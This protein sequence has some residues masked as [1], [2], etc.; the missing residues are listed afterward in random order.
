M[1]ET[2]VRKG[3]IEL[4]DRRK[5]GPKNEFFECPLQTTSEILVVDK[6][7]TKVLATVGG[8]LLNRLART[9]FVRLGVR[10]GV[11]LAVGFLPFVGAAI[12]GTINYKIV[13]AVARCADVYYINKRQF[14]DRKEG[15]K[16]AA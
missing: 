9:L 1:F 7:G 16:A 8:Q 4:P 14:L 6:A 10:Q 5:A 15:M 2:E 13:E 12:C 3:T 11:K